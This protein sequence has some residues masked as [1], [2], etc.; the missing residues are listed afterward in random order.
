[1]VNKIDGNNYPIYTRQKTID[2]PDTGEKFSL[3]D[4]RNESTQ[5]SKGRKEK[6]ITDGG[7]QLQ[8]ERGGVSLELSSNGRN[9]GADR[10]KQP[11]ATQGVSAA[12]QPSLLETI[13]TFV[14]TAITAVR[15]FFRQIWNDKPQENDTQ[16]T[17][18][19][20]AEDNP[21][22]FSVEAELLKEE[23]LEENL[24]DQVL[25][26]TG[27][28]GQETSEGEQTE[29]GFSEHIIRQSLLNGD[30]NQV[31]SLLTNNGKKTLA[32]NSTLLTSYDRHGKV[33]EPSASDRGKILYGDRNSWKR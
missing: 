12:G 23:P 2:L 6:E 26:K 9:A 5:E 30:M 17:P 28:A 16:D 14:M 3:S 25:L 8:T 10:Q 24:T 33:V 31:I 7:K 21:S 18:D 13:Q 4:N 20:T 29:A 19:L 32:K 27:A 1:M 22:A 11:E 15:D